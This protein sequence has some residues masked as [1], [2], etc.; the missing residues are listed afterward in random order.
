LTKPKQ[1]GKLFLSG[2]QFVLKRNKLAFDEVEVD[3]ALND[4]GIV[5]QRAHAN[6]GGGTV[7]A[8]GRAPIQA[9]SLGDFRGQIQI[10]GVSIPVTDGVDL[11]VDADL[12]TTWQRNPQP[13]QAA[14]LPTLTGVVTVKDFEYSRAVTMNA[15]ITSLARKGKRTQFESYDPSK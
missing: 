13:D 7:E 2:G 12:E 10:R 11:A 9:L 5:L 3:V 15:D 1:S 8:R 4:N 6:V 14:P